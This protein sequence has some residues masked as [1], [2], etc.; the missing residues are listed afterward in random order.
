MVIC[1]A[2]QL[3]TKTRTKYPFSLYD[4]A[5]GNASPTFDTVFGDN[6]G[7]GGPVACRGCNYLRIPGYIRGTLPDRKCRDGK[8]ENA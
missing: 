8:W 3:T 7:P 2:S 4:C 1:R 5:G 6:H